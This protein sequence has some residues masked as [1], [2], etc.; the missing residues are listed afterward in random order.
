[1]LGAE[2]GATPHRK[3]RLL[4]GWIFDLVGVLEDADEASDQRVLPLIKTTSAPLFECTTLVD[5]DWQRPDDCSV[6]CGLTALALT[7]MLKCS[8]LRLQVASD[9]QQ[10]R[11]TYQ[12][13]TE[14]S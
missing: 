6:Q 10:R 12:R 9:D 4:D 13:D 3:D 11:W 7:K 2:W 5:G 1:M 14:V 8:D